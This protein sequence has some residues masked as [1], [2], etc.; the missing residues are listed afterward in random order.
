MAALG[1]SRP[2]SQQDWVLLANFSV[3][4]LEHLISSEFWQNPLR[5][6]LRSS[7]L[8]IN[9]ET[10]A[11]SGKG[12]GPRLQSASKCQHQGLTPKRQ[13]EIGGILLLDCSPGSKVC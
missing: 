10:E 7:F 5:F 3:P 4:D 11:Q 9:G 13:G 12:S 2:S 6:R 8:L 1:E